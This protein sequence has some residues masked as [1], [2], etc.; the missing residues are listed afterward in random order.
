[1]T[2]RWLIT[3]EKKCHITNPLF[4]YAATNRI[5]KNIELAERKHYHLRFL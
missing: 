3:Q 4:E 2:Y 1:M 5:Q